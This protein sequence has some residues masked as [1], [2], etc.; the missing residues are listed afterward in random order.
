ME[1]LMR[2]GLA[3]TS[4]WHAAMH[5]DAALHA[6]AEVIGLWDPDTAAVAAMAGRTGLRPCASLE[7]LLQSQPDLVV[8]TGHP[9]DVPAMARACMGQS[10]PIVLEKPAAATTAALAELAGQAAREGRFVAVPL[11]NRCSPIWG[12]L[13]R[14]RGLGRLGTISHAQ[15]R[16][17]NGPPERYR[18]D[19]VGWLLDP[20][21]AGGGALRNLGLHGVDA[22]L[23]LFGDAEPAVTGAQT[24][25]ALYSEAV[26]EYAVAT[27]AVPGG[28]VVTVEAGCTYASMAAGGDFEWRVSAANAYL[29]DRGR[30]CSVATLDDATRRD[31]APVPP[32]ERYRHFMADTLDRLRRG[33]P[34][35]VGLD[36]YVRAMRLID[37]IYA[38]AGR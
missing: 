35:S 37:R 20:A 13:D 36:H 21:V 26:E 18:E 27:L 22:A 2:I 3:G 23:A 11:A 9:A 25:S 34:P 8:V 1:A 17:V 4:H 19:G 6:G 16:I 38:E 5:L 15:F 29:I 28:P 14:L 32:G 30:T 24:R 31:I 10:V 7:A 33:A 12:E